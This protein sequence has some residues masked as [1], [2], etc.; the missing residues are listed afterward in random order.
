MT[1]SLS[2]VA[3][4]FLFVKFTGTKFYRLGENIWSEADQELFVPVLD[5]TV[6]TPMSACF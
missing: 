3:H 2:L 5:L 4:L 6:F 1:L